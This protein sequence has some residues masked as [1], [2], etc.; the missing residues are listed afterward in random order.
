MT[1][2]LQSKILEFKQV[3]NR[4]TPIVNG[5]IND[6]IE[7]EMELQLLKTKIKEDEK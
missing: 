3:K 7:L 1:N 6:F 5:Y 4:Y 2:K